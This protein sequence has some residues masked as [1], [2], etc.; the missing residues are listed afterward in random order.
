MSEGKVLSTATVVLTLEIQTSG[1]NWGPT[2]TVEQVHKQAKDGAYGFMAKL[3]REHAG[4][5]VGYKIDSV[6]MITHQ[7]PPR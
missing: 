6:K 2:C 5:I 1:S 7:E 4:E 3:Q